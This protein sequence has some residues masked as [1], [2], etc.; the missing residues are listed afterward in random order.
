MP[1]RLELVR[2]CQNKER[3]IKRYHVLGYIASDLKKMTDNSNNVHSPGVRV[4]SN[5]PFFGSNYFFGIV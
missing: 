1:K 5:D 4:G 3:E 2:F